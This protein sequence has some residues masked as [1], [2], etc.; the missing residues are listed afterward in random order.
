M[1]PQGK[2][3][4]LSESFPAEKPLY[5]EPKPSHPY[6]FYIGSGYFIVMDLWGIEPQY[7]ECH[8]RA[9]PLSYRPVFYIKYITWIPDH[10]RNDNTITPTRT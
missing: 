10:V 6:R 2:T 3:W 8:S 7:H 4:H 5:Q 9:L 1:T